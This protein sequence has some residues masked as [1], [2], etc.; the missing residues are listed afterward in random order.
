MKLSTFL[1]TAF[2]LMS[3]SMNAQHVTEEQALQKAQE[4]MNK[5]VTTAKGGRHNAPRKLRKLAKAT[6]NDAYYIFNAEQNGGFVIVS[7]DERTDEILAYST[8]GNIDLTAMP[9]N[10]QAW[11]K[12]YEE[13]ILAIPADAKASPKKIPTHPAVEPLLRSKWAQGAPYNLQCPTE[14]P[15]GG[16]EPQHCVTGCVATAMAQIMY[17]WQYPQDYT[18]VVP[19]Y[20]IGEST[21]NEELQQ[22][23][24]SDYYPDLPPVKFDWSNMKD[25]YDVTE[26][27]ASANAVA[28]LMHYC[29][30]GCQMAYGLWASG[31]SSPGAM[32]ALLNYFDYDHNIR[33]VPRCGNYGDWIDLYYSNEEWDNLI[34]MELAERRPVFMVGASSSEGH[35]FVCDGYDGDGMFHINWGWGGGSNCYCLLNTMVPQGFTEG[36][37]FVPEIIIGIQPPTNLPFN[38]ASTVITQV[39]IHQQNSQHVFFRSLSFTALNLD[40]GLLIKDYDNNLIAN[41]VLEEGAL[42]NANSNI[43]C[44]EINIDNYA[45][46]NGSYIIVPIYRNHNGGEW[47]EGKPLR[48]TLEDGILYE[49]M[50]SSMEIISANNE[51]ALVTGEQIF[52][53]ICKANNGDS[54]SW[55]YYA[56]S[57]AESIADVSD[58]EWQYTQIFLSENQNES[59]KLHCQADKAGVYNL[60][61]STSKY[62]QL[63]KFTFTINR[64]MQLYI[65]GNTFDWSSMTMPVTIGNYDGVAYDREVAVRIYPREDYGKEDAGQVFKSEKLHIEPGERVKVDIPCPGLDIDK[66]Y[67]S[68][69][70][71]YKNPDNDILGIYAA[72]GYL[73]PVVN[74]Y[75]ETEGISYAIVDAERDYVFADRRT[76]NAAEDLIVPSVVVSPEDGTTYAVKGVSRYFCQNQEMK[77]VVLS[78]GITTVESLSF[79]NCE[80]LERLT[81]PASINRIGGTMINQCPNLKSIFVKKAEVPLIVDFGITEYLFNSI[82]QQVDVTLYVPIG[83]RE[84]YAKAWP[85]FKNI[86]EMDFDAV[87]DIADLSNS[88]QYIIRTKDETRGS[89]GVAN[90][91]L[92]ST[93]PAAVGHKCEEATPFAILQYDGNYYLYSTADRKFITRTGGETDAPGQDGTHAVTVTKNTNGY[94]MFSF[95]S[96]GNVININDSPGIDINTWGQKEDK[97]DDGNQFAIEEAGDFDPTDALAMFVVDNTPNVKGKTFTLCCARGYVGYNGSTLC[98]TTQ[99][100]ASEF[101]IVNYGT[102]NYLYDVTNKAFVVHSTAAMAGDKGNRSLES[103]T[104]FA[105]AVTG[106]TWGKT[107]FETY[108]WYLEDSFTNW[109]NMDGELKV[110]MNTWKEFEGGN[111]GNTYQVEIVNENFDATEAIQMLDTYFQTTVE[112]T[113]EQYQAALNSVVTD[114]QYAIYTL[115]G[116][117]RYYLT[118]EGYLTAEP[119]KDCVLTFTRTEGDGLFHSPGWKVDACFTNPHLSENGGA[120]GDLLPQGHI[121]TDKQG[122][123]DW[124]GQVWYLGDNGC[125]AVR[126]TNAVS[127]TWGANTYW[128]VLDTNGDGVPEADYS[129]AP[130]FVWQLESDVVSVGIR[131]I[132]NGQ[133]REAG[134]WYTLDGRKLSGKPATKGIFIQNSKKV[135]VR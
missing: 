47:V 51:S 29:G 115:N 72:Y 44:P 119:T 108:P 81:F 63:G 97:W 73:Q 99:E 36:Y 14:I 15:E 126:A 39:N 32:K 85:Q 88:K 70:M 9:E 54:S 16:T 40:L 46:S 62:E 57:Q 94:F 18:T 117:T 17:Y 79:Q 133:S 102:T 127:D 68:E 118:N 92:A 128:T 56:L 114:T 48:V 121:L 104:Y 105:A 3:V 66:F 77:S 49:A 64:P 122:R 129:W 4:F 135:V 111:G 96:T 13:Q 131:D 7:G 123:D 106:L 25:T 41:T 24:Y 58:S 34:Y 74:E 61:I 19:G 23:D 109:M 20:G 82:T 124:D 90:G 75:F 103:S 53:L 78:E 80:N 2:L 31:G 120:S 38:F 67:H 132:D 87:N 55:L 1:L 76:S 43:W 125:Y 110:C 28:Q 107:G 10:M 26:T 11:L 5:K 37:K 71:Y 113:D 50:P 27:D 45:L 134:A 130:A 6:R 12:G 22:W 8:E 30:K 86:V 35:A 83:S 33:F 65:L 95:T 98:S 112:V 59:I 52:N 89:L 93:N 101:A 21:W 42:F 84:A 60:Y 100:A 116:R 69:L 91:E